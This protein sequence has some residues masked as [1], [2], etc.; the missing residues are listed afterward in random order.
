MRNQLS[1]CLDLSQSISM[2]THIWMQTVKFLHYETTGRFSFERRWDNR[3][4]AAVALPVCR[5][6]LP[7]ANRDP[8]LDIEGVFG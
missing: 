1:V 5:E 3:N 4:F 6:V 7:D 8:V 2:W